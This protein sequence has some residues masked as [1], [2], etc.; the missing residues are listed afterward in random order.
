MPTAL[1][2]SAISLSLTQTY[3]VPGPLQQLPH[4]VHSNERPFW[5]QVEYDVS[6]ATEGPEGRR[7]QMLELTQV[8]RIDTLP[9]TKLGKYV[10]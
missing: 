4:C 10:E 7:D 1:A 6:I 9:A 8:Y 5:Y 3:P 2:I